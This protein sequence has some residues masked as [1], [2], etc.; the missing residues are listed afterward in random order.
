MIVC[1]ICQIYV[2][3]IRCNLNNKLKYLFHNI[4]YIYHAILYYLVGEPWICEHDPNKPACDN[5]Q[6]NK[7]CA[8]KHNQIVSQI[9]FKAFSFT[10]KTRKLQWTYIWRKN[11]SCRLL[12]KLTALIY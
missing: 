4:Y 2:Y 5:H 10:L 3:L 8:M 12:W 1:T 6:R 9:C 7:H 11:K